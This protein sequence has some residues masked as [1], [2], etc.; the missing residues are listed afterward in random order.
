[1]IPSPEVINLE[2]GFWMRRAVVCGI[3]QAGVQPHSHYCYVPL[4]CFQVLAHEA[5]VV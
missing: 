3:V 2:A 5:R 1:M 4:S